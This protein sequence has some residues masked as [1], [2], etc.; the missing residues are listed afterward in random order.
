MR[1]STAVSGRRPLLGFSNKQSG[2]QVAALASKTRPL[3]RT[4]SLKSTTG[5]AGSDLNFL[6]PASLSTK[7]LNPR[8]KLYLRHSFLPLK[9]VN[10]MPLYQALQDSVQ[11]NRDV[12]TLVKSASNINAK[13]MRRNSLLVK[14]VDGGSFAGVGQTIQVPRPKSIQLIDKDYEEVDTTQGLAGLLREFARRQA[15]KTPI[16]DPGTVQCT[17]KIP[18]KSRSHLGKS[19]RNLSSSGPFP[20]Y[21]QPSPEGNI[22]IRPTG[23][24]A[25][26]QDQAVDI[27]LTPRPEYTF[28]S[29]YVEKWAPRGTKVELKRRLRGRL[30]RLGST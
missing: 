20:Q 15:A 19:P 30:V 24:V 13:I 27:A 9:Q 16:P 11:D 10:A 1:P 4:K 29:Q 26:T 2:S 23:E 12:V 5:L 28:I 3:K 14:S 25:N 6:F 7:K 18:S 22:A 21:I 8:A 17:P